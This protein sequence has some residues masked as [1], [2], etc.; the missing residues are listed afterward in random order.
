MNQLLPGIDQ[1]VAKK[2]EIVFRKKGIQVYVDTDAFTL[3]IT[4]L[5]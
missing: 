3:D 4:A 5:R 1:D 2:L